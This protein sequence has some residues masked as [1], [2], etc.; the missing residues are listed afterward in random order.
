MKVRYTLTVIIEKEINLED[1]KEYDDSITP[2]FEEVQAI[3]QQ[4]YQDDP[5][6]FFDSLVNSEGMKDSLKVEQIPE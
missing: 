6:M 3:E 5:H 4:S 1:Y 2:E